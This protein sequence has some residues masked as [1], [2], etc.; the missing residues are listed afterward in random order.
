[1]AE[2]KRICCAIDFSDSSHFALSE[3]ADLTRRFDGELTLFHAYE[4]P[5]AGAGDV[6]ASPPA[7]FERA[8][9]ETKDALERW[10][11]EAES[12]AGRPVQTTVQVGDASAELVR[13]ALEGGFDLVVVGTHGHKGFQRMMLGSVAERVVRRAACP[14]LVVR[15]SSPGRGGG[16]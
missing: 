15:R 4:L 11:A 6:L 13:F 1:M 3:A 7:I 2:W 16:K 12:I 5:E 8:S 10:R 14:V 9:R